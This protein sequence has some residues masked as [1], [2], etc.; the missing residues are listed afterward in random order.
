M[1]L[2]KTR[3][4]MNECEWR[5]KG[6]YQV[7]VARPGGGELQDATAAAAAATVL[8]WHQSIKQL[9][10][11]VGSQHYC[12]PQSATGRD[13]YSVTTKAK[14]IESGYSL[15]FC[16][17]LILRR[18]RSSVTCKVVKVWLYKQTNTCLYRSCAALAC[19][20]GTFDRFCLVCFG[21]VWFFWSVHRQ[22]NKINK[23][24]FNLI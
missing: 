14:L 13:K 18:N 22:T 20:S 10:M 5:G 6:L 17:Y 2:L 16:W 8:T 7:F 19:F 24:L 21:W 1:W 12:N 9:H 15:P 23:N 3:E 11:G 4:L